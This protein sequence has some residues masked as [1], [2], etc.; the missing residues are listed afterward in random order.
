MLLCHRWGFE[1]FVLEKSAVLGGCC[2]QK[3]RERKK[4]REIAVKP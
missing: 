2:Y 4:S 1:G 3:K